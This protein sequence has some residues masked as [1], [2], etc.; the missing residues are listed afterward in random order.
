MAS[1][2][3]PQRSTTMKSSAKPSGGCGRAGFLYA[4]ADGGLVQIYWEDLSLRGE[5][6]FVYDGF[7]WVRVRDISRLSTY[8]SPLRVAIAPIGAPDEE[9]EALARTLPLSLVNG[10]GVDRLDR[11]HKMAS[12]PMDLLELS[13]AWWDLPTADRNALIELK[14]HPGLSSDAELLT[15]L[16]LG[17]R[18]S[19]EFAGL[20]GEEN[21]LAASAEQFYLR[22]P[23]LVA[24]PGVKDVLLSGRVPPELLQEYC[25]F[26]SQGATNDLSDE[27]RLLLGITA[28]YLD[29]PDPFARALAELY[30]LPLS[31]STQMLTALAFVS[32][33]VPDV[34]SASQL[35]TFVQ[36]RVPDEAHH[37]AI[38][39]ARLALLR[40][41]GRVEEAVSVIE[42]LLTDSAGA[43]HRHGSAEM[44]LEESLPRLVDS[45]R[46]AVLELLCLAPTARIDDETSAV[47]AALDPELFERVRLL[48]HDAPGG[49][50]PGNIDFV[51]RAIAAFGDRAPDWLLATASGPALNRA[52]LLERLPDAETAFRR[53]RQ[54]DEVL[55]S[56]EPSDADV[57]S[58]RADADVLETLAG[59]LRDRERGNFLL[60]VVASARAGDG[61]SLTRSLRSIAD[62]GELLSL[63]ADDDSVTTHA[64][65]LES[66]ADALEGE[67]AAAAR[68]SARM[69]RALAAS[70][71]AGEDPSVAAGWARKFL[72]AG[73]DPSL[74]LCADIASLEERAMLLAGPG[75][76]G[77]LAAWD[78]LT[79]SPT[80]L[81]ALLPTAAAAVKRAKTLEGVDSDP[82]VRAE[83]EFLT[84]Y[85]RLLK[86]GD[87]A[88]AH[89]LALTAL[90]DAMLAERLLPSAK[91][92]SQRLAD[93]KPLLESPE[94]R[95][96]RREGMRRE[97]ELWKRY[98]NAMLSGDE[99][100]L[101]EVGSEIF[102]DRNAERVSVHDAL[103]FLPS[104]PRRCVAPD[105]SR[106][107]DWLLSADRGLSAL[108]TENGRR[109]LG[110]A[111]TGWSSLGSS[112]ALI[113]DLSDD[114]VARSFGG[115]RDELSMFFVR[116]KI[117]RD[118]AEKS[119]V[120]MRSSQE[121]PS[122]LPLDAVWEDPTTGVRGYF[123]PR[124]DP[125]GMQAGVF[126]D[127]C[128]HPDSA[129]ASCALAGQTHPSS[130]FF[131][132]EDSSGEIIA[133]SWVWAADGENG[134]K[135]GV[136]FD[137]VEARLGS[138]DAA[139]VNAVRG[140]YDSAADALADRFGRVMIGAHNDIPTGDLPVVPPEENLLAASIGYSGYLG[141]SRTQRLYR[142]GTGVGPRYRGL[143]DGFL[144]EEGNSSVRV[145]EDGR[146]ELEG[147][148]ARAL[149]EREL[150]HSTQRTYRVVN[151]DG[152]PVG[153]E[154]T[155]GA[156][157][158]FALTAD[159]D[160]APNS[161]V[162]FSPALVEQLSITAGITAEEA[163]VW[164]ESTGGDISR[165][166]DAARA[167]LQPAEYAMVRFACDRIGRLPLIPGYLAVPDADPDRRRRY[168]SVW[169]S[170]PSSAEESLASPRIFDMVDR[171]SF[172][173]PSINNAAATQLASDLLTLTAGRENPD[174]VINSALSVMR[175]ADEAG[176][177]VYEQAA[178]V[179][180]ALEQAE[181]LGLEP[182][183]LR[184]LASV[185]PIGG[186]RPGRTSVPAFLDDDSLRLVAGMDEAA[187]RELHYAVE[188]LPANSRRFFGVEVPVGLAAA[189]IPLRFAASNAD[190]SDPLRGLRLLE[191]AVTGPDAVIPELRE[192]SA[193]RPSEGSYE[194]S[195]FFRT[196]ASVVG[197][198]AHAA[199]HLIEPSE[200]AGI[201]A[202]DILELAALDID[203]VI[204]NSEAAGLQRQYGQHMPPF[205][206]TSD[207]MRRVAESTP[208]QVSEIVAVVDLDNRFPS[209]LPVALEV[210]LGPDH[211]LAVNGAASEPRRIDGDA[212]HAAIVERS[213]SAEEV[214]RLAVSGVSW[215][216]FHAALGSAAVHRALTDGADREVLDTL[217]R[218]G[219]A[220]DYHGRVTQNGP[221]AR[222]TDETVEWLVRLAERGPQ[223][224]DVVVGLLREMPRDEDVHATNDFDDD[225]DSTPKYRSLAEIFA[226]VEEI[227]G[228]FEAIGGI[229][230]APRL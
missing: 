31:S 87:V 100:L 166:A 206:F 202:E 123:L 45:D 88:A 162:R 40:S 106:V 102:P 165:A 56:P 139:R 77:A 223:E 36:D 78:A 9:I 170:S 57:V 26:R 133:Q 214:R 29:Q 211:L 34:E 91:A 126:T 225:F 218:W 30:R 145:H 113:K 135:S 120:A 187:L 99:Q 161:Y 178:G 127:C 95:D 67:A 80:T 131:V 101:L 226:G 221:F 149:A 52:R 172:A 24:D 108:R 125:R 169:G 220:S 37:R 228:G 229:R 43:L 94:E 15:I 196:V 227:A 177:Q 186:S 198:K 132:V 122:L 48:V 167:G 82:V 119:L 50:H 60:G 219:C 84:E 180:R 143:G 168:L 173:K 142:D 93:L 158:R 199:L 19:G 5:A 74:L 121:V 46:R 130:G 207:G 79:E 105:G 154:F 151:I 59:G 203:K 49:E 71:A 63:L 148:G 55:S 192:L 194:E 69:L 160:A 204:A 179:I 17:A 28:G 222:M 159:L 184:T 181:R 129:G 39:L 157:S 190:S 53:C 38:G 175:A 104:D 111:A 58:A 10:E 208:E 147:P 11:V 117:S 171:H 212:L 109:S 54:L 134:S 144:I 215:E 1:S 140:V 183:H 152:E 23:L 112:D 7:R 47:I 136:I 25:L 217:A 164:L 18:P 6:L 138:A 92:A 191:A 150:A 76:A 51:V 62:H 73:G 61:A 2:V 209:R 41:G 44:L 201:P 72:A 68:N 97:L 27:L 3:A 42:D 137:N 182:Q 81:A 90:G 155:T 64:G 213:V 224:R 16:E 70:R 128:Q 103:F 66:S 205:L 13:A 32:A 163:S 188:A 4:D 189:S 153:E 98:S 185:A 83:R 146:V 8:R 124:T 197:P 96:A 33:G 174:D 85:S 110:L 21:V 156:T 193:E 176:L 89:A 20:L 114:V 210:G 65:V 22:W 200:R 12:L 115:H 230:R 118:S 216:L 35:A 107:G 75:T 141:D 14:K 116:S 195:E 86:S